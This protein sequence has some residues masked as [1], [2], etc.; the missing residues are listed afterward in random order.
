MAEMGRPTGYKPEYVETAY[1]L[2]CLGLTND[3]LGE[4]L[5][6][7]R[8]TINNWKQLHPDFFDAIKRGK[9]DADSLVVNALRKKAL[10]GDTTAMIFWLKN[11]Q[12]KDWRDRK[13]IALENVSAP[14]DDYI[15]NKNPRQGTEEEN[16]NS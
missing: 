11:R 10:D 12:P 15:N 1:H 9:E 3:Q 8:A 16:G 4:R 14:F 6:V 7:T 5:G 13:N 2:C